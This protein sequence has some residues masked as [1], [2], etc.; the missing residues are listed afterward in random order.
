MRLYTQNVDG[1]DVALPSLE[2]SVPLSMKGPWPRTIQ[3]HGGLE[4]MVCSK[5]NHLSTFE[6]ALFDGPEPPLC[7]VCVETDKVRTD[8]A[9]KRSHG[10][11]KLRPRIV[12]YNEHNPDEEAIGA[13][14]GSDLRSRPDAVIV[15]GTSMKIPGVRRIVREMCGVVRGRRDGLAV[16][17]NQEAP[18]VGKEFED[19]WDLIV[20]GACDEVA[21]QWSDEKDSTTCTESDVEKAKKRSGEVKVIINSSHTDTSAQGIPTPKESPRLKPK[22]ILRVSLPSAYSLMRSQAKTDTK[23]KPGKPGIKTAPKSAKNS[24]AIKA[25]KKPPGKASSKAPSKASSQKI[26]LTFKVTKSTKPY[27]KATK[28]IYSKPSLSLECSRPPSTVMSP[29]SPSA[30][31]NNGPVSISQKPPPVF[32]NLTKYLTTTDDSPDDPERLKRRGSDIV[33]PV[34]TIPKDMANLLN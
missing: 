20:K 29:L 5:C 8:H 9:G 32:P 21:R 19:C 17:I 34:G 27:S 2:T 31:R 12:L 15:V 28:D 22:I 7:G 6:A 30:A 10:I 25:V 1:I 18:P 4:K 33:S 26:D 14:V 11:G 24:T 13:V 3:L 16:W 23:A